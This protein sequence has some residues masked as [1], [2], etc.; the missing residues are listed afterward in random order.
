MK[1]VL[2]VS[3]VTKQVKCSRITILGYIIN[4][5]HLPQESKETHGQTRG[6]INS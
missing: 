4:T 2:D 6:I 1:R 3:E 5:I